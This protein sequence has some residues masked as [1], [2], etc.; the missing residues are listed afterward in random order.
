MTA[1]IQDSLPPSATLLTADEPMAFSVINPAGSSVF[2]LACDHASLRIPQRLGTLALSEYEQRSHIAWDIGAAA[3]AQKLAAELDATLILQN[4]SRLVIDCNR[5]LTAVDS[6]R[7]RGESGDIA[8]N[9]HLSVAHVR[10]RQSEVF[11]PYHAALC[12]ILEQRKRMERPTVLIAVHSCTPVME[13]IARPWHIGVMYRNKAFASALMCV[14]RADAEIMVGD[15]LPY[16]IEDG[17]DY[18]LP[19]HGEVGGIAHAGLEIRQDL[20]DTPAGQAAWAARLSLALTQAHAL[21]TDV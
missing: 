4:Y 2:V 8:G 1:S 14:L 21:M 16:A 17:V 7:S 15:N 5:P 3:V 20:I 11:E 9:Q 6:I 12:S 10:S 18:T 13:G 19:T